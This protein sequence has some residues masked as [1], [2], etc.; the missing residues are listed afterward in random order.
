[1][2][3]SQSQ[4]LE[5]LQ[6]KDFVNVNDIFK[7]LRYDHDEETLKKAHWVLMGKGLIEAE[8]KGSVS[9][10]ITDAGKALLVNSRQQAENERRIRD[11]EKNSQRQLI[12]LQAEALEYQ[13]SIR[14]LEKRLKE[15][16][17]KGIN[18]Q[19]RYQWFRV[20]WL[21]GGMV[22]TYILGNLEPIVRTFQELRIW[23]W[24]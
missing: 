14:G 9:F 11:E 10:R 16:Q 23:V 17:I 15:E 13:Q 12:A 18:A 19:R 3:D 6:G 20:L 24:Q 22:L 7:A 21:I 5:Y 1:M 4:M 8:S 2:S